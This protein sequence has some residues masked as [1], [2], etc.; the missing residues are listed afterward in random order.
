MAHLCDPIS[1]RTLV[2][3]HGDLV[4]SHYIYA[5]FTTEALQRKGLLEEAVA[6]FHERL[7]SARRIRGAPFSYLMYA[8]M[9]ALRL[10]ARILDDGGRKLDALGEALNTADESNVLQQ[11]FSPC[12]YWNIGVGYISEGS[13]RYE[14]AMLTPELAKRKEFLETAVARLRHGLDRIR[15]YPYSLSPGQLLRVGDSYLHFIRALARLFDDTGDAGLLDEQIRASDLAAEAY[16]KAQ[17]PARVA[18]A[19]WYRARIHSRKGEHGEGSKHYARSSECYRGAADAVPSLGGLYHDF[20]KYMLAWCRIEEARVSHADGLYREASETYRLASTILKETNRWAP[21]SE[22]YS[23]CA[24][25]E[26]AEA[27]CHEE[28]PELAAKAFS[29]AADGFAASKQSLSEW[30]VIEGVEAAEK[31]SWRAVTAARERY[32]Q[33]RA[34]F[35]E[36]KV[37]DRKGKHD[38]SAR[39]FAIAAGI[40]EGLAKEEE[41][42]EGK[43]EMLSLALLGRAWGSMKRAETRGNADAFEEAARAFEEVA[44]AMADGNVAAICR[45]NA[46]FCRALKSGARLRISHG[47]GLYRETKKYLE[48]AAESYIEA[49]MERAAN[50]TRATEHMFDGLGFF[51]QA[52]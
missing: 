37:L 20:E 4:Q 17:H 8:G 43:Q 42:A 35:E 47:K 23:A 49:G 30:R 51:A 36:A 10:L 21:L 1:Q 2:D 24:I 26:G 6:T 45:G 31:D 25:L 11:R 12:F 28:D 29:E 32:C 52:E 19:I 34:G 50:W 3:S 39:R 44:E 33:A 13:I 41:T 15:N 18:E 46:A 16:S 7:P 14:M 27:L 48:A 40:L 9:E 5:D 38:V 22:H